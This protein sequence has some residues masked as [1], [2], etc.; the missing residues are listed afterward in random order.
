M[1]VRLDEEVVVSVLDSFTG[2]R[3]DH[4]RLRGRKG[5][6]TAL[7]QDGF[8]SRCPHLLASLGVFG[9]TRTAELL[10]GEYPVRKRSPAQKYERSKIPATGER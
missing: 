9:A 6:D 2:S 1:R 4:A 5:C 10:H 7:V 3:T 8:Q